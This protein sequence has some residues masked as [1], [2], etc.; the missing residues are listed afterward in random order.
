MN[1]NEQNC[2][3]H[4]TCA[5]CRIYS[6]EYAIERVA[7]LRSG[8]HQQVTQQLCDVQHNSDKIS[9]IVTRGMRMYAC[10]EHPEM[11]LQWLAFR[12][13]NNF[14]KI[15]NG[16]L[17]V[18]FEKSFLEFSTIFMKDYNKRKNIFEKSLVNTFNIKSV[19]SLSNVL[20]HIYHKNSDLDDTLVF[21]HVEKLEKIYGLMDLMNRFKINC[22]FGLIKDHSVISKMFGD[23]GNYS[24]NVFDTGSCGY[25]F[26]VSRKHKC[27]IDKSYITLKNNILYFEQTSADRLPYY[28]QFAGDRFFNYA[29]YTAH[30]FNIDEDLFDEVFSIVNDIQCDGSKNTFIVAEIL[31]LLL[32]NE[33]YNLPADLVQNVEAFILTV[34]LYKYNFYVGKITIIDHYHEILNGVIDFINNS[35]ADD[36]S[37]NIDT[38]TIAISVYLAEKYDS[39]VVAKHGKNA[40]DRFVFALHNIM[41][42][43][44]NIYGDDFNLYHYICTDIGDDGFVNLY[45]LISV[46]SYNYKIDVIGDPMLFNSLNEILQYRK[47]P[48]MTEWSLFLKSLCDKDLASIEDFYDGYEYLSLIEPDKRFEVFVKLKFYY[49]R[50]SYY[51]RNTVNDLLIAGLNHVREHFEDYFVLG[52]RDIALNVYKLSFFSFK[53]LTLTS[54]HHPVYG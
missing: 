37:D 35:D 10:S 27:V 44:R 50:P 49:F 28:D 32:V 3:A 24:F 29:V 33:S 21:Q 45:K 48:G 34:M 4:K 47:I 54:K 8:K 1:V 36:F 20:D 53:R 43:F 13:R 51:D 11:S 46:F 19:C 42:K 9:C 39:H 30:A 25:A 16:Q 12:K 5:F 38:D 31:K 26:S 18:P 17:S 7:N 22:C 52:W 23:Y 15:G 41:L 40:F 14:S 6:S 2:A